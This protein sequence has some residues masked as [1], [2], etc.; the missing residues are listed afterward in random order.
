MPKKVK[1]KPARRAHDEM[2]AMW[3][4]DP[5]FKAENE[6]LEEEYQLLRQLILASQGKGSSQKYIAE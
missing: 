3:M 6:A 4:R 5:A 1:W 2:V